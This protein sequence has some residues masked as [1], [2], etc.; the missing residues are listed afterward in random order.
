VTDEER[1]LKK[2]EVSIKVSEG[3]GPFSERLSEVE[4]TRTYPFDLIENEVEFEYEI[5]QVVEAVRLA[6]AQELRAQRQLAE[7]RRD[8]EGLAEAAG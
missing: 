5:E 8:R 1:K 4:I 3:T 2:L 6:C 7:A